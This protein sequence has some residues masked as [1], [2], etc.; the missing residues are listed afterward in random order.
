DIARNLAANPTN[1]TYQGVYMMYRPPVYPYTLSLFYHFIHAP[2]SQLKVARLVSVLFF[3]LTAVVVYLLTKELFGGEIRGAIAAMFFALNPLAFTMGSRELVHSEFTFFYALAVYLLYLG[4]KREE[5]KAIYLAF[6]FAGIAILTRYT[7]LSIIAVFIAYLWLSEYWNWAKKKEYWVGFGLLFAVLM[8]WMY[9]GHLHYGGFLRPFEI[10]SRTVTL[11]EPVSAF[12]YVKWLFHD[13]GRVLPVLAIIGLISLRQNE[14][15]WLL[16]SWA[17]LGFM[18][19]LSVTHKET[20]FITFLAPVMGIL[21][22]R[23][24][25]TLTEVLSSVGAKGKKRI[26]A[27]VVLSLILA[28]PVGNAAF[29]LKDRWN[30][31]G[32]YESYVLRYAS[33]HYPGE[34][35]LVSPYL[36]T[37]AGFYYPRAKVDMILYRKSI[38]E[39]ISGGYYDV[40]IHKDP[41]TYLNILTSGRYE[42]VK[43][44]YD[45]L[46]K[47]FIRKP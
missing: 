19:I 34:R 39:R 40:I 36:Y 10:A 45:G 21:A 27:F 17:F 22:M 30:G 9:L 4:R 20:R 46:F 24:V 15:G 33:E 18:M 6:V 11:A 8:P 14:E 23:G 1:F 3:G 2:L 35:I 25:E 31:T 44:F 29:H 47:I 42:L 38:E 5:K 26:L 41:N 16:L 12:T 43:E 13:L 37:M 32:R 28:V 7:G